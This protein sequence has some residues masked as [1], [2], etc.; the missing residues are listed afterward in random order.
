M[1]T[2]NAPNAGLLILRLGLGV[3]FILHGWMKLFGGQI[4]FVQEMLNI[5]GLELPNLLLQSAA[6]LELVCG[7][8]IV[9][10]KWTRV[11]SLLIALEMMLVVLLFHIKEGFF[12]VAVPNI[13]LAY[14]FE[15]HLALVA[16]LIC[17]ALN[18]PGTLSLTRTDSSN[19]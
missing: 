4:S 7:M 19:D 10:G 16:G 1:K 3:I 14:G 17:L 18:G 15:F 12:I 6:V 13:P 2:I 11:G 5:A 8:F 9:I